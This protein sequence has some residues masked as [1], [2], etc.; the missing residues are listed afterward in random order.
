MEMEEIS[1]NV[2]PGL[3]DYNIGHIDKFGN[4]KTTIS[5]ENL[6]EK[7]K[8]DDMISV[9]INNVEKKARYVKNLFGGTPGELVIYP[10]SSGKKDNPYVEITVWRHFTEKET[11]TGIHAF[12]NPSPGMKIELL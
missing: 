9:K 6:K 3:T 12:N 10:G 4:I 7:Y 1:S 2:I 5:M 11:T 8:Y